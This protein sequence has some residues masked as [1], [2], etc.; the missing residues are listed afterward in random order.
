MPV[1]AH[2]ENTAAGITVVVGDTF[3]ALREGPDSVILTDDAVVC[4]PPVE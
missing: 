3:G 4:V 1:V 2:P